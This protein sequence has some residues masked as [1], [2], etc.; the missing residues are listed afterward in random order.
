MSLTSN[1]FQVPN[2]VFDELDLT[3]HERAVLLY[4]LRL[5]QHCYP[6][7]AK[8]AKKTGIGTSSVKKALNSL[9]GKGLI[10]W[11]SGHT[12]Q[13]NVYTLNMAAICFG[14]KVNDHDSKGVQTPVKTQPADESSASSSE[15]DQFDDLMADVSSNDAK[16]AVTA[17]SDFQNVFQFSSHRKSEGHG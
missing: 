7:H 8:I 1:Y 14:R 16:L 6:S 5:G 17:E 11:K 3:P 12:N 4:L 2:S 15:A 13:S 10:F 9:F